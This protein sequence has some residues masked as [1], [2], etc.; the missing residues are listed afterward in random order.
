VSQSAGA[1]DEVRFQFGENWRQFLRVVDDERIESAMR[2]LREMLGADRLDGKSFLDA[3]CG[4]GLF[5]L[6]ARKLGAAVRSFDL[7]DHSVACA[8][9]LKRRYF[10]DDPAWIVEKASVLDASHLS[11]IGKFDVVYSWGV[12]HHTGAMWDALGRVCGLVSEGGHLCVSI[13]NDQDY[14][15]R[16]WLLVK[17]TYHRLPRWLRPCLV[18]A[19][20]SWQVAARL[21]T[22]LAAILLR[23]VSLRNPWV[24]ISNWRQEG[25]QRRRRGMHW[26][27][28][29]VDWVGGYPFEVARP[30]AVFSFCRSRGFALTYLTTQGRGHGCNE[31]AFVKCGAVGR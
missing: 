6:A 31:F 11:A 27:H 19:V 2:S 30:E 3:G 9:E 8:M 5:S 4:S 20:G 14:V 13:Y 7:D 24:P 21:A 16:A 28:D 18:L 15:S 12:L 25:R 10:P 22:T 26:W 17:Q 23:L 29:L 1:T